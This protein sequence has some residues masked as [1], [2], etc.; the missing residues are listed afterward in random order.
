MD[1][2]LQLLQLAVQPLAGLT[3]SP[4]PSGT[5]PAD[6]EGGGD[7]VGVVLGVVEGV[8]LG[9]VEGVVLGVVE[10]VVL[11]VVA[12][13]VGGVVG[14]GVGGGV[15]FGPEPRSTIN[16]TIPPTTATPPPANAAILRLGILP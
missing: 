16:A 15:G 6:E 14:R 11:G 10:G 8:V 3:L 7:V 12:G 2:L 13:V 5:A 9:L 4:F 1:P